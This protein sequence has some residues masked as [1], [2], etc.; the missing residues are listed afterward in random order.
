MFL[1]RQ[2]GWNA[3][4]IFRTTKSLA[5]PLWFAARRRGFVRKDP[6]GSLEKYQSSAKVLFSGLGADE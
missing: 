4:I 6:N 5:L 2:P 1:D 3:L